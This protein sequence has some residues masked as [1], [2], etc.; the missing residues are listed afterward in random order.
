AASCA[1]AAE[2]VPVGEA[3]Q[4][5]SQRLSPAATGIVQS[6]LGNLPEL[7]LSIFALQAGLFEV[8]IAALVGSV[9]GSALF[10]LAL[11]TLVG[12]LR[13]GKL[14]FSA[15]ANRLYATELVLGVAALTVP[16]L[17][18]Q[19]GAPDFGHADELSAVVSIV[20]LVVFAASVPISL[21]LSEAGPGTAD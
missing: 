11:A 16:F 6:V 14:T 2:P 5:L 21:R 4:R 17:A 8:V 12:G 20:L 1:L 3:T 7:F 13:H 19:R 9:L 18:T 15:A 10:V